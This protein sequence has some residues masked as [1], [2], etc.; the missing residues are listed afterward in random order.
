MTF[1]STSRCPVRSDVRPLSALVLLLAAGC[2]IAPAPRGPHADPT[3]QRVWPPPPEPPRV[4][5][6][7]V[8]DSAD[9]LVGPGSLWDQLRDA[10]AGPREA[11]MVH[12][13]AL[14]VDER[15]GL[16][17]ADP[18]IPGLHVFDWTA[19]THRLLQG[20]EA[21][22]LL[23]PVAVVIAPGSDRP[24]ILDA[25]PSLWVS[26]SARGAIVALSPDGEV[27]GEI[28]DPG[29]LLRPAG[30]AFDP[31]RAHLIVA[32]VLAHDLKR[33]TLRGEFVGAVGGQGTGPGQFNFPTHLWRAP[34]GRLAVTDSLNFRV[35]ILAPDGTPLG[36]VGRLGDAPGC[37]SR[38][39]GVAVDAAGHLWVV[40]AQFENI[41]AFDA[42]GNLL[43]H[44]GGPGQAPG[45][46]WLP[47]GLT[48]DAQGRM[49]VADT[50]NH[51][52]QIFLLMPE[53]SE[54]RVENP[55]SLLAFQARARA[56][57]P[58]PR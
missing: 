44:V 33:Y 15:V 16:V 52:V 53:E 46:F 4:A 13:A 57:V 23:S 48:I 28:T 12:P 55:G 19:G 11:R 25:Q 49:Y 7:Q 41:Q 2:A 10:V 27:L 17:V 51:R 31:D 39:K 50:H 56:R 38:P 22:P 34:D 21:H 18:G 30:L 9:D 58:L 40:D 8:V 29:R 24:S 1:C 36:S 54:S 26:D 32:D 35:Q 6:L 3:L 14:A 20:D 5:L 43:L 37:L 45:A 47:S 42:A